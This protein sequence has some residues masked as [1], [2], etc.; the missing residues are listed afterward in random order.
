M[1]FG[2]L[3]TF[4]QKKP[5]RNRLTLFTGELQLQETPV[6][7]NCS[8]SLWQASSPPKADNPHY[9]LLLSK[10]SL[11][12]ASLCKWKPQSVI[13]WNM[14]SPGHWFPDCTT[15]EM[16][17]FW[18]RK[19]KIAKLN[20]IDL[21]FAYEV[22]GVS[23]DMLVGVAKRYQSR[24]CCSFNVLGEGLSVPK[25]PLTIFHDHIFQ[26]TDL[27]VKYLVQTSARKLG[28]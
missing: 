19:N 9:T 25:S 3:A 26:F 23:V 14:S 16:V 5:L 12:I 18:I 20:I 15:V 13:G 2:L 7:S 21:P 6:C 27:T 24:P 11:Y 1:G 10:G 22:V 8:I 4:L 17:Y 28:P